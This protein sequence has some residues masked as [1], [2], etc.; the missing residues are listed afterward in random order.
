M[1][2]RDIIN[3]ILNNN[4]M[5]QEKIESINTIYLKSTQEM[6]KEY[7]SLYNKYGMRS[8][9]I[10]FNPDYQFIFNA[11]EHS[12]ATEKEKALKSDFEELLN[13]CNQLEYTIRDINETKSIK[14]VKK[15]REM[16]IG[17]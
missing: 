3:D 5:L 6:C 4:E 14:F 8:F 9:E 15:M 7:I 1:E 13:R 12:F 2:I 16:L 11:S 10:P 17:K